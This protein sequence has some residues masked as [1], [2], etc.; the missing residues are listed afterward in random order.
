MTRKK[1]QTKEVPMSKNITVQGIDLPVVDQFAEGHV[2]TAIEAAVLSQT[3][4]ENL[5]NN[6]ANRVKEAKESLGE[7]FNIDTPYTVGEGEAAKS[8][9]S[10]SEQWAAHTEAYSFGARR[11]G[12][13]G[14]RTTDPVQREA[15]R[16][17]RASVES[18]IRTKYGKLDAVAKEKIAELVESLAAREDIQ[19]KARENIANMGSVD[20]GIEV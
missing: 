3:Y 6:F 2:L 12:G 11:V 10:I 9:A 5:R 7:A 18:A 17:A 13:G 20:L 14:K 1:P 15:L 19:T 8:F 16:I 4:N